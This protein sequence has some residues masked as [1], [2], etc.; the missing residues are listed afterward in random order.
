MNCDQLRNL[1]FDYE[2]GILSGMPLQAVEDHLGTCHRCNRELKSVRSLLLQAELLGAGVAPARD[3]WP[4]IRSRIE[5]SAGPTRR[6]SWPARLL[7]LLTSG[8][9]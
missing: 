4:E 7:A 6:C 3:L 5:A 2:A 9:M 8:T 1:L